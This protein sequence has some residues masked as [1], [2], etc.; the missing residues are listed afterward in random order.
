MNVRPAFE[1]GRGLAPTTALQDAGARVGKHH[2]K[3]A[4]F[5]SA[6]MQGIPSAIFYLA[7]FTSL[8]DA[9]PARAEVKDQG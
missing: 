1:N 5:W 8:F 4:T 3:T 2:A 6:A 7:S 9:N